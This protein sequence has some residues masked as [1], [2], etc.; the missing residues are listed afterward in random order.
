VRLLVDSH[1]LIWAVDEP[2]R[3][4]R[5]VS[6]ALQ[7]PANELLLSVAT[8][9]ESAIKVGLN[10]L[11][12][13]LPFRQWMN[14]AIAD[15]GLSLLPITVEYAEVQSGLPDHHRDPFDRLI[16]AQALTEAVPVV[17]ADPA[18]DPYGVTRLW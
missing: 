12:L 15:L 14:Q 10:K 9:W 8:V 13:T 11:N 6:M 16:I 3:L 1:T 5:V 2:S 4:S 18:F 17:S 7:D